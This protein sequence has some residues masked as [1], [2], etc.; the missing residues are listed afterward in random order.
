LYSTDVASV[1]LYF[2]IKNRDAPDNVF[3]E[4]PANP[5]TGYRISGNGQIPDI[6][7]DTWLDNHC[8]FLVKK[9][10]LPYLRKN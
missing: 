8:I 10:V 6:Q 2:N 5:K 3:A 1:H 7:P 4:Y 9:I